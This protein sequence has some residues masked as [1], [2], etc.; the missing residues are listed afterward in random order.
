VF[1]RVRNWFDGAGW[2]VGLA[3]ALFAFALLATLLGLRSPD[4]VLWTGQRVSGTEQRGIVSYR[5]HG[6]PY[7]LD[8]PGYGS[9]KAVTLYL[10][11][12]DP[13]HARVDDISARVEAAL[14]IGVPAVGG[15]VLLVLGGT[16]NHRWAR[17]NAKLAREDPWERSRGQ[18]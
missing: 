16:R 14:L 4:A 6:E 5:W 8:V 18:W 15:V 17:R 11:P 10:D 9:S 1:A 3:T 7:T 12:G 2:Y 13:S